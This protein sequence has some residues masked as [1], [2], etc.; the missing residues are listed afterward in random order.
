MQIQAARAVMGKNRLKAD[1]SLGRAQNLTQEALIDIR[2]SV[3]ALRGAP[4]DSLLLPE[5]IKKMT[6]A[7]ESA[8]IQPEIIVIGGPRTISPQAFMTIYRAAQEGINN[9]VKHSRARN[10]SVSVDYTQ[11][12]MVRLMIQDDG[13]GAEKMNGGFGLLGMQ[14]RV[15][16]VDGKL[17]FT[18]SPGNGFRLEVCVPG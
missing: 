3:A 9:T 12:D 15:R 16:M 5:E 17:N 2:R 10:I 8:G 13:V 11:S 18:T 7:C 4:V 6:A 14:E 1:E